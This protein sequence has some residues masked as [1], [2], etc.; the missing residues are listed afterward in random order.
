MQG[1]GCKVQGVGC[2]VQ[3]AGYRVWGGG[4]GYV[5]SARMPSVVSSLAL[6]ATVHPV[7]FFRHRDASSSKPWR[8]V[9]G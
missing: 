3:G 9:E 2:R 1:A 4:G 6:I 5:M 7:G 8:R